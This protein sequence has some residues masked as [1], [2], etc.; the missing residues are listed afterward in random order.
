[1]A[2]NIP[3][4]EQQ[5]KI[6][7]LID[8][9]DINSLGI[10]VSQGSGYLDGHK[11]KIAYKH[12][13]MDEDGADIDL[14]K[15]AKEPRDF[16]FDCFV[17]GETIEDAIDKLKTLLAIVDMPGVRNL[18]IQYYGNTKKIT[19]KCFREEAVKVVKKFRYAKNVWTFTLILKEYFDTDQSVGGGGETGEPVNPEN[20]D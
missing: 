4:S 14:S 10:Y 20:P 2:T 18:E 1:M 3:I 7:Y 19:R 16:R 8:G 12:D 5:F 17:I 9:T 13:W 11:R 15:F 6:R